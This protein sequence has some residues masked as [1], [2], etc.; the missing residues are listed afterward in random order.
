MAGY[1][2]NV[3]GL[4]LLAQGR[5]REA[6]QELETAYE[7]AK[8][9]SLARLEGF[10][11][12]NLAWT[13]LIEGDRTAAAAL[14]DRATDRFSANRVRE[15]ESAAA[16]AAACKAAGAVEML[17][18]LRRA[19]RASAANPDVYQPSDK[20]LVQLAQARD[21]HHPASSA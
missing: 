7:A 16:L 8:A 17:T 15:A 11:S 14:A 10:T 5:S 21:S 12:L 2:V 19:V 13:R 3:R 18:G 9:V 4:V 6:A 1:L 20:T